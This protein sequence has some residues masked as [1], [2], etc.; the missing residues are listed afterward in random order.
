M[1]EHI[2]ENRLTED[3]R[4]RFNYL[5]K[6][7]NF[8]N[9]D[10]HA[11]NNLA[12]GNVYYYNVN[13]QMIFF[14]IFLKLVEYIQIILDQHRLMLNVTL[15]YIETQMIDAIWTIENIENKN[16]KEILLALNKVFRIQN[17]L[18]LLH[19]L[20]PSKETN[21]STNHKYPCS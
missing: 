7:V 12:P 18:F 10:I 5:S 20:Q 14:N 8:T 19:Y 17:D 1:T 9:N 15:S 11:L 4:Y 2:D 16:K 21:K 13:G 6:F 3:L